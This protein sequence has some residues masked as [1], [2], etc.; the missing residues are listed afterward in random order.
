MAA[1]AGALVAASVS[2]AAGSSS[3]I[4]VISDSQLQAMTST[5]GRATPLATDRTVA[6]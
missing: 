4:Q 1:A 5:I 2:V 3:S 6:H